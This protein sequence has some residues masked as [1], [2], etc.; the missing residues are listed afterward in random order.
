MPV[1]FIGLIS[2]RDASETRIRSGAAVD[3][4]YLRR[5]VRAH[6]DSDF[7]RVLIGYAS[8]QPDGLQVAA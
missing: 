6:E 3:R 8:G 1:E 5:F 7:D 4:D 2:T